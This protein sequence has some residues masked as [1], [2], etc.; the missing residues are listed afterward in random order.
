MI[1]ITI[2]WHFILFVGILVMLLVWALTREDDGW[3]FK[4][5]LVWGF[6]IIITLLV[7]SIYGGIFWW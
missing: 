1:E 7:I 4:T 3:G 2:S 6:Y 5:I